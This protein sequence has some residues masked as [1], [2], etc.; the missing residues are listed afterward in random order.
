MRTKMNKKRNNSTTQTR[1]SMGKSAS[2]LCATSL[3]QS[4][5]FVATD[6]KTELNKNQERK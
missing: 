3:R 5:S 6:P 1:T 2:E 4:K